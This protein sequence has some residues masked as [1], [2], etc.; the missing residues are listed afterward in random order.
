M[1]ATQPDANGPRPRIT[2]PT[3]QL[4]WR[5]S[6]RFIGSLGFDIK[7]PLPVLQQ[8][9][10]GVEDGI[11]SWHDVPTIIETTEDAKGRANL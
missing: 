2:Q 8:K 7:V 11:D 1:T 5:R 6:S 10:T 4:R 9:W 3:A